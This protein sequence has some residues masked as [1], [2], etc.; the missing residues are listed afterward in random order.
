M[1][2]DFRDFETLC[3]DQ[4][5]RL[6]ESIT[7]A[8]TGGAS[9]LRWTY[10]P[11]SMF[12]AVDAAAMLAHSDICERLATKPV[13]LDE[14]HT[15]STLSQTL[16]HIVNFGFARIEAQIEDYGFA[17]GLVP[18]ETCDEAEP[19]FQE[20]LEGLKTQLRDRPPRM[21]PSG[22]Q[23][24]TERGKPIILRKGGGVESGLTLEQVTI[25]GIKYPAGSIVN[26]RLNRD[27]NTT[28]IH[29]PVVA[30]EHVEVIDAD[31]VDAVRFVRLSMAALSSE[32]LAE[33]RK[34][35]SP[36]VEPTGLKLRLSAARRVTAALVEQPQ[37]RPREYALPLSI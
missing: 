21:R 3:K 25:R 35:Q 23:I 14:A 37:N 9:K 34:L 33:L 5:V 4:H 24:I 31:E 32:E 7:N 8:G 11:T 36:K 16:A 1:S 19:R 20:T 2:F 18:I 13:T 10:E 12:A 6:H 17:G 15:K 22:A 28:D 26:M 29:A 30:D 27:R